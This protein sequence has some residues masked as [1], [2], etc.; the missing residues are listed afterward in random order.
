M[1][2]I[3]FKKKCLLFLFLIAVAFA[4]INRSTPLEKFISSTPT[5]MVRIDKALP[6]R[7]VIS[8]SFKLAELGDKFLQQSHSSFNLLNKS[9][10]NSPVLF[11]LKRF[12]A[13]DLYLIGESNGNNTLYRRLSL[14]ERFVFSLAELVYNRIEP[15]D[16]DNFFATKINKINTGFPAIYYYR[17]NN[18]VAFSLSKSGLEAQ[19]S[20]SKDFNIKSDK[21]YNF[22]Y[23][24][25]KR[26]SLFSGYINIEKSI[27]PLKKMIATH[28]DKEGS[29]ELINIISQYSSGLETISFD[30]ISKPNFSFKLD[31]TYDYDKLSPELINFFKVESSASPYKIFM[32][33]N[34]AFYHFNNYLDANLLWNL[35]ETSIRNNPES[36]Q[37]LD[38]FKT[39]LAQTFGYSIEQ[40]ILP[41]FGNQ[42]GGGF[43]KES[44]V[45]FLECYNDV[46]IS[47]LLQVLL[48][49]NGIKSKNTF[50][51]D[52]VISEID[53]QIVSFKQPAFCFYENHLIF[54]SDINHLKKLVSRANS[55]NTKLEHV[56]IQKELRPIFT[57]QSSMFQYVD[58]KIIDKLP[59]EILKGYF[60]LTNT[61]N[62]K[63]IHSYQDQ[64]SGFINEL[65]YKNIEF[66]FLKT[67]NNRNT[68]NLEL[69][70]N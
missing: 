6:V 70:L 3:T 50:Y 31:M 28:N 57:K 68:F 1:S 8:M 33:E 66:V 46:T 49:V 29:N 17:K 52:I 43:S 2:K 24:S 12:M 65:L 23:N 25:K 48:Q 56:A 64:I 69:T 63:S 16:R 32:D 39:G 38:T 60:F 20:N 62:I 58:L 54:S 30:F 61:F 47:S 7:D 4:I 34:T 51:E 53:K 40:D 26:H 41:S 18:L 5:Y 67:G 59:K 13:N 22:L 15:E 21:S 14:L 27:D 35:A 45:F 37:L 19:I 55:L 44:V 42:F 10:S 9:I 36:S 11:I